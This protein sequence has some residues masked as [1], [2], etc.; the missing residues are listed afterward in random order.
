MISI[1][2]YEIS[3]KREPIEFHSYT[4]ACFPLNAGKNDANALAKV[5]G[6]LI[7]QADLVTVSAPWSCHWP[8]RSPGGSTL[9]SPSS[10]LYWSVSRSMPLIVRAYKLHPIL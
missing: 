10:F 6:Q 2:M 8:D 4:I 1:I 3:Q 5:K 7:N 9:C